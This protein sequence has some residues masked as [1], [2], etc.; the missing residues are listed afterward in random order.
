MINTI[1]MDNN[2]Y[3]QYMMDIDCIIIF[4]ISYNTIYVIIQC[5]L[6]FTIFR[7]KYSTIPTSIETIITSIQSVSIDFIDIIQT[8]LEQILIGL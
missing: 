7:F 3:S 1:V 4:S 6:Y 2:I 5:N 8:H